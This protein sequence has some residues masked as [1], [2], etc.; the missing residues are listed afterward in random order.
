VKAV[1]KWKSFP[2][3]CPIHCCMQSLER[4]QLC[5]KY[6]LSQLPGKILDTV[7]VLKQGKKYTDIDFSSIQCYHLSVPPNN[8]QKFLTT[9]VQFYCFL[10]SRTTCCT[11]QMGSVSSIIGHQGI[12]F[13]GHVSEKD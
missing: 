12:L 9:S 2:S 3:Q 10:K 6:A 13:L 1:K 11:G 8:P 7:Y 5:T 4:E